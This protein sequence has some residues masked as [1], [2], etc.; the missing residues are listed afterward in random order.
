MKN[1]TFDAANSRCIATESPPPGMIRQL[2]RV[3]QE[4][5]PGAC[6]ECDFE[7]DCGT[8]GCAVLRRMSRIVAV[9]E[10]KDKKG[11]DADVE[12]QI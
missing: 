6:V 8:K 7:Q 12:T 4:G 11:E 9:V 3:A 10:P 1:L 2:L 5:R